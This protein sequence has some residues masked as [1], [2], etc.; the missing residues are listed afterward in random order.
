MFKVGGGAVVAGNASGHRVSLHQD[1]LAMQMAP[2]TIGE[3][4]VVHDHSAF[5]MA[6]IQTGST[7]TAGS[8]AM[9]GQVMKGG[10]VY[11]GRPPTKLHQA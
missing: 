6:E 5:W 7:M 2:C 3:R 9:S 10:A 11:G 1:A 4:A 8:A